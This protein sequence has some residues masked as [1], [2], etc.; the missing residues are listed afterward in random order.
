MT[1]I[2]DKPPFSGDEHQ[3]DVMGYSI[4]VDN[5]HFIEWYSFDRI[6]ARPDWTDIWGTE[7]YQHIVHHE[8]FNNENFNLAFEPEMQDIVKELRQMLHDG[9]RAAQP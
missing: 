7:L 2:P 6:T 9:W 1:A 5:F 4:R 8:P 3:E